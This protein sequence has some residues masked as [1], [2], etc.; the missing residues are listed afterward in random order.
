MA[1]P[2][3]L[4][5]GSA[6]PLL[7]GA[8]P[9]I[10]RIIDTYDRTLEKIGVPIVKMFGH[11]IAEE[12]QEKKADVR[13][14]SVAKAKEYYGK[15]LEEQQ[16]YAVASGNPKLVQAVADRRKHLDEMDTDGYAPSLGMIDLLVLND[17]IQAEAMKH[18]E[19]TFGATLGAVSYGLGDFAVMYASGAALGRLSASAFKRGFER[20]TKLQANQFKFLGRDANFYAKGLDGF[21][22]HHTL[23]AYMG[24]VHLGEAMAEDPNADPGEYWKAWMQGTA[25]GGLMAGIFTG[26]GWLPPMPI[27]KGFQALLRKA[28]KWHDKRI[29]GQRLEQI[30]TQAP[31]GAL[32]FGGPTFL[33]TGDPW[34]AIPDAVSGAMWTT[35]MSNPKAAKYWRGAELSAKQY[36]ATRPRDMKVFAPKDPTQMREMS[37]PW[38]KEFV[39]SEAG[40]TK[41]EAEVVTIPKEEAYALASAQLAKGNMDRMA[42]L[43]D[44]RKMYQAAAKEPWQFNEDFLGWMGFDHGYTRVRYPK[45]GP[46][47][48]QLIAKDSEGPVVMPFSEDVGSIQPLP[49]TDHRIG[50]PVKRLT[51]KPEMVGEEAGQPTTVTNK[52]IEQDAQ[53]HIVARFE[54]GGKEYKAILKEE[55]W[56][57]KIDEG[58]TPRTRFRAES[59]EEVTEADRDA[60]RYHASM[61][62][63]LFQ[64]H[65]MEPGVAGKRLRSFV[66]NENRPTRDA[67]PEVRDFALARAIEKVTKMKI[68][69][70]EGQVPLDKALEAL[71]PEQ[72]ERIRGHL[73]IFGLDPKDIINAHEF[74]RIIDPMTGTDL[75][76]DPH[77]PKKPGTMPIPKW[78]REIALSV[79]EKHSRGM[80]GSA[81]DVFENPLYTFEG[82]ADG[83]K[84]VF[85]R[86]MAEAEYNHRLAVKRYNDQERAMWK[87]LV[88]PS[89]PSADSKN[90]GLVGRERGHQLTLKE[91]RE[92][93]KKIGVLRSVLDP[94]GLA[95]IRANLSEADFPL[96]THEGRP[97]KDVEGPAP[98]EAHSIKYVVKKTHRMTPAERVMFD[99][100]GQKI[101][102]MGQHINDA[103]EM[104]GKN[105]LK[106]IQGYYPMFRMLEGQQDGWKL[107]ARESKDRGLY[108]TQVDEMIR[109]SQRSLIRRMTGS[110]QEP[111]SKGSSPG[112]V[113]I[114]HGKHRVRSTIPIVTDVRSV[115]T[116]LMQNA[117]KFRYLEPT[118]HQLRQVLDYRDAAGVNIESIAPNSHGVINEWLKYQAGEQVM[119]WTQKGFGKHLD[120]MARR[121]TLNAHYS[122]LSGNLRTALIQ[123]SAIRGALVVAGPRATAQALDLLMQDA[124]HWGIRK[125]MKRFGYEWKP[126]RI[127]EWR[128]TYDDSF[129]LITREGH[130][131]GT[132]IGVDADSIGIRKLAEA[133]TLLG[134]GVHYARMGKNTLGEIGFK[135]LEWADKMTTR[136]TRLAFELKLE[137]MG[138]EGKEL[139]HLADEW[140]MKVAGSTHRLNRTP[141]QRSS[142]GRMITIFQNFNIADFN[143]MMNETLGLGRTDMTPMQ[144]TTRTLSYIFWTTA[145]NILYE[146]LVPAVM[147]DKA[148]KYVFGRGRFHSPFPTPLR[149]F[150][151]GSLLPIP[152]LWDDKE[153]KKIVDNGYGSFWKDKMKESRRGRPEGW[154]RAYQT[155]KEPTEIMP[156]I[157]GGLKY[158]SSPFGIVPQAIED[159][160]KALSGKKG[161]YN[162]FAVLGYN[163]MLLGGVPGL[164]QARKSILGATPE[165]KSASKPSKPRKPSKRQKPKTPLWLQTLKGG[166]P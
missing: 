133:T 93:R 16:R 46:E 117:M 71:L 120:Q 21:A 110:L 113:V 89:R 128:R 102:E 19:S 50:F 90:W 130:R 42:T 22:R 14:A 31:A 104:T 134:K 68:G 10:D 53:G 17:K 56:H 34:A 159:V 154:S 140:T 121:L 38:A 150:M 125:G 70:S 166:R 144:K 99:W 20:L 146:D 123:F 135:P 61:H 2:T 114:H 138:Y 131:G 33:S 161:A 66:Q 67:M 115:Y 92:L 3:G 27:N 57:R 47:A 87:S 139:Q 36:E 142:F 15:R 13:E 35:M 103:L 55:E 126:E 143:F 1:A 107:L 23:P 86:P 106:H 62:N 11:G 149:T 72:Y 136:W 155:L 94:D 48:E 101:S 109:L 162:P 116:S 64:R 18:Q 112:A 80:L 145:M 137:K 91:R 98:R 29:V 82:L 95:T 132:D 49:K 43:N 59:V 111:I 7:T 97:I 28:P 84:E 147:P 39:A 8:G 118:V 51:I 151:G 41:A 32:V 88:G 83:L 52:R 75:G 37:E 12:F 65:E 6:R 44:A 152:S 127:S 105:P 158:G 5:A 30:M 148:Q 141:W 26:I 60:F 129:F 81:R 73:S 96:V 164:F 9:L 153:L 54:R 4:V 77:S 108:T 100:Y 79:K 76:P 156:A 58:K 74:D 78:M 160:V 45:G 165:R 124:M 85:F 122:V 40:L 69:E 163:A 25:S 63:T 119:G 157:G 24:M